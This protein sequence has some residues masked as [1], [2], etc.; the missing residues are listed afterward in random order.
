MVVKGVPSNCKWLKWELNLSFSFKFVSQTIVHLR[1]KNGKETF[2]VK[3]SNLYPLALS[4]ADSDFHRLT[5]FLIFSASFFIG[6][7][8]LPTWQNSVNFTIL[9]IIQMC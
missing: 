5:T 9:I 4:D 2:A 8:N 7:Q 6:D 3:L 1:Y